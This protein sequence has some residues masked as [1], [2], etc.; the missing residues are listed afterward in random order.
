MA[1]CPGMNPQ[2]WKQD[3]ISEATCIHCGKSN[4]EFWKDDVKRTCPACGKSMYNPRLGNICLSWCDKA[5]ECIGNKDINE[6]KEIYCKNTVK[7]SEEKSV[8]I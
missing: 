4:M 7:K 8:G 2:N 3:D 5:D 6:W 1:Q